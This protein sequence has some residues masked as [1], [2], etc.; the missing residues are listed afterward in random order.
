[1]RQGFLGPR[2]FGTYALIPAC[3]QATYPMQLVKAR[4]MAASK[5]TE[6]HL[7]YT[8]TLDAVLKILKSEGARPSHAACLRPSRP[9][10]AV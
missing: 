9:P 3:L 8:G 2:D 1:M 6:P 10:A 7:Q 4:L 5:S